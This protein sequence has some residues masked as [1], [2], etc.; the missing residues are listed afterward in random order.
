MIVGI[1]KEI[2]NRERRV[3]LTPEGAANIAKDGHKVLIEQGAGLGSGFTD[4]D[5]RTAGACIVPT[6]VEAWDAELVVKVK[7][8]LAV[9]YSFLKPNLCLFTFLHL[10]A[11]QEL[12][13]LLL[14]KKVCAIAYETV[15]L[16]H[17]SLPLL[18]PMSR[19]AG[20]VAAQ[21]GAY[22]LQAENG[23]PFPGKGKLMGGVD[24][25]P[26]ARVLI[27][28]GGNAGRSAA[29]VALGMGAEVCVL[30]ASEACVGSLQK[31]FGERGRAGVFSMDAM[32]SELDGCDLLIGATLM[33]GEHAA[34]LLDKERLARMHGGV[35]VDIAIDQGGISSTS[36]PTSYA[37]PVYV[38]AGVL[39]CCLPNLP[40]CVPLSATRAL[41]HATLPFVQMLA[42]QGV[43]SAIKSSLR[44]DGA[45]ARGVNTWDGHIAHSG[46]AHALN[47]PCVP[48]SDMLG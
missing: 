37:K 31:S 41:T 32:L 4:A 24:G 46:V 15:Q 34:H 35:F 27:I 30:D 5:Y 11:V 10:A 3:A 21:M 13:P 42:D 19:V 8:P 33:V 25:V 29:D 22:L 2:K 48:L 14:Q 28:G 44:G 43:E 20:R 39:H 12:V 6:A 1:P 7:E 17:G 26:P 23:T 18:A 38:E 47:Q 36:R 45:L 40:A 16:D 9:E